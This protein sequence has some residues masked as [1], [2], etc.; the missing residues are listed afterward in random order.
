MHFDT[1]VLDVDGTLMDSNYHHVRAWQRAFAEVGIV[2]P[3]WRIHRALGMGGDR[4]VEHLSGGTVEEACGDQIRCRWERELDSVLAEITAF[5]GAEELLEQLG[6]HGLKVVLATSGT[7]EHTEHA[8]EVLGSRHLIDHVATSADA[9][10]SKPD[11]ELLTA[12]RAAVHGTA[13]IMIGD[14][15]WDAYAAKEAGMRMIGVLSGGVGR[16]EL[17]SAG[18]EQVYPD[19]QTLIDNIDLVLAPHPPAMTA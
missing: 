15:V 1:V 4:L 16:D 12:A 6:R 19:L 13:A 5:A 18:A 2:V 14:S 10:R 3:G 8:L 17:V 11:P 7:A 9:S